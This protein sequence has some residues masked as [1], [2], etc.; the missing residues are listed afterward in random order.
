MM[1]YLQVLILIVTI[2]SCNN[3]NKPDVS[4][5]KVDISIERFEQSFF[6]IDTNNISVGL[7]DVRNRFPDFYPL[8]I[9]HILQLNPSDSSSIGIIKAIISG[10]RDINNTIQS[11]YNNIN[12]L[13]KELTESFRYVKY[14]F[15][16][17][18]VPGVITFIGTLDAPGIVLTPT[19]LGIGLHQYAG[20]NFSVYKDE[21]VQQLYPSYISRRFDQEYIVPNSMKAVVDDI[22]PDQTIGKPLIEQMVEKGKQLYLLDHFLPDAHDT[23]KTGYTKRQLDW[24]QKNEGNVWSYIIQNENIYSIE[25]TV[26]QIYMGEAP[27]TQN[28]PEDSPGNIGQWIGWQIMKKFAN[29]SDTLTVQ[30]ILQTPAK[31]IFE[32]A[33]YR[34]K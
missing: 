2:C 4:K 16:K 6:Q 33:K 20:K 34:P 15:P 3:S 28:M 1:K 19:H 31:K 18:T 8:F 7:T 5:I 23:L 30:K 11:K 32:G 26:I 24:V 22:Y 10:Y 13:Q 21:Q 14:Y 27:F 17:Y 25:P 29:S 12:W 9:Q